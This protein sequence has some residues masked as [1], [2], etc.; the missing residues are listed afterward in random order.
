MYF[1]FISEEGESK[2]LI[3]VDVD[4]YTNV[5]VKFLMKE[6]LERMEKPFIDNLTSNWIK[7]LKE[8][9]DRDTDDFK[10][11][12]KNISIMDLDA[13]IKR[14]SGASIIY[15]TLIQIDKKYEHILYVINEI[16]GDKT[17]FLEND[18]MKMVF[19]DY[20]RKLESVGYKISDEQKVLF[21]E[22]LNAGYGVLVYSETH[23]RLFC[24]SIDGTD[25]LKLDPDLKLMKRFLQ[26][27]CCLET[28]T[29][30]YENY[31][32][33]EIDKMLIKNQINNHS[34]K[35]SDKEE[36]F[37]FENYYNIY[38]ILEEKGYIKKES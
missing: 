24:E 4:W 21:E 20:L 29:E 15:N 22:L 32:E 11:V 3:S 25:I 19:G 37:Y 14:Q 31:F 12:L 30:S 10:D 27:G 13:N 36:D 9:R 38:T 35:L 23:K 8:H 7:Y 5:M 26:E 1:E 2:G 6:L 16:E 28:I 33:E 34:K 17:I 18:E